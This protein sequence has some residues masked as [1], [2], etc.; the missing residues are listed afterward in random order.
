MSRIPRLSDQ[1]EGSSLP[2][3]V[4]SQPSSGAVSPSPDSSRPSMFKSRLPSPSSTFFSPHNRRLQ[5]RSAGFR[6]SALIPRSLS[7]GRCRAPSLEPPSS[8]DKVESQGHQTG[9]STESILSSSL[10][11][12]NVLGDIANAPARSQASPHG[13]VDSNQIAPFRKTSLDRTFDQAGNINNDENRSPD[14]TEMRSP[15]GRMT[16]GEAHQCKGTLGQSPSNAKRLKARHARRIS[17]TFPSGEV[18]EYIDHLEA[19]LSGMQNQLRSLTSPSSTKLQSSKLRSLTTESRVLRQEVS[20]WEKK[21][22]ERVQEETQVRLEIEASLKTRIRSLEREMELKDGRVVELEC[23]VER[24]RKDAA[25]ID[26][27]HDQNLA[28]SRR[29]DVLT[30]LL[31]QSPAKGESHRMGSPTFGL[32][33]RRGKKRRLTLRIP[34][35]STASESAQASTNDDG[36]DNAEHSVSSKPF[37]AETRHD[38]SEAVESAGAEEGSC[39]AEQDPSATS[40]E[41]VSSF[42]QAL[43]NV[44]GRR[45]ASSRRISMLSDTAVSLESPVR[46]AIFARERPSHR[47]RRMR[48]FIG[49][50][51][52]PKQLILPITSQ[53]GSCSVSSSFANGDLDDQPTPR[54]RRPQ[55]VVL[56][57]SHL[58]RGSTAQDLEVLEGLSA[59]SSRPVSLTTWDELERAFGSEGALERLRLASQSPMQQDGGI[60]SARSALD[61]LSGSAERRSVGPRTQSLFAE[62]QKLGSHADGELSPK[63]PEKPVE[64]TT[65]PK[66]PEPRETP[67]VEASETNRTH[68]DHCCCRLVDFIQPLCGRSVV[69]V[70]SRALG[71]LS[72]VFL[73]PARIVR[74]V[75]THGV[76]MLCWIKAAADL[77]WALLGFVFRLG[78]KAVRPVDGEATVEMAHIDDVAQG[79]SPSQ[80]LAINNDNSVVADD[81]ASRTPATALRRIMSPGLAARVRQQQEQHAAH[82]CPQCSNRRSTRQNF[83]SLLRNSTNLVSALISHVRDQSETICRMHMGGGASNLYSFPYPYRGRQGVN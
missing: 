5:M 30:E 81:V 36:A 13:L 82:H 9:G 70:A 45:P 57:P 63:S 27:M 43:A 64:Q 39:S 61:G 72:R 67:I 78:T 74:K 32:D 79:G 14:A 34:R 7:Q 15:L 37:P 69:W 21:F 54:A 3:T 6:G 46:S 59:P 31:A 25:M 18:S 68:C 55:S 1:A 77:A 50:S 73:A 40:R 20:E 10:P 58:R 48:R 66:T 42:E 83:R 8:L 2:V 16:L 38:S 26:E 29:L 47:H 65:V 24:L 80:G 49:G 28:L 75:V 60:D 51:A 52:R 12:S 44:E 19:Q 76:C 33:E 62:L 22:N 23:E 4:R 17:A 11:E 71:V 56:L 41:G 53:A 35:L